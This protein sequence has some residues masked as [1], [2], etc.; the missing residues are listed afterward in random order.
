MAAAPS[1]SGGEETLL[2]CFC[3]GKSEEDEC[4][5]GE[6]D[7]HQWHAHRRESEFEFVMK[8]KR[9]FSGKELLPPNH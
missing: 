6:A 4:W 3:C 2:S 1:L 8:M 7:P 9:L 5:A